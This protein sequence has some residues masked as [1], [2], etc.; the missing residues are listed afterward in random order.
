[1]LNEFFVSVYGKYCRAILTMSFKPLFKR[2]LYKTLCQIQLMS[3]ELLDLNGNLKD[4]KSPY[5]YGI[6]LRGDLKYEI[7]DCLIK[8]SNLP[9]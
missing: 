8:I 3:D 2:K 4:S 9:L 1:M 6:R 7:A 5:P